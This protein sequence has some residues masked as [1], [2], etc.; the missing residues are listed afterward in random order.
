M[1]DC[2]LQDRPSLSTTAHNDLLDYYCDVIHSS[3]LLA[4]SLSPNYARWIDMVAKRYFS[5]TLVHRRA[6]RHFVG[7][8][9][10]PLLSISI[11]R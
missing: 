10:A 7:D 5:L 1:Q 11:D 8:H 6:V 2:K 9:R 3:I 4:L